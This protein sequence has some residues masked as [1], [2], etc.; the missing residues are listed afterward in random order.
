MST[1]LLSSVLGIR[2]KR[3]MKNQLLNENWNDKH[4]LDGI[5]VIGTML[6]LQTG[7]VDDSPNPSVID[8]DLIIIVWSL[9]NT[10]ISDSNPALSSRLRDIVKPFLVNS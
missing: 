4:P 1:S 3:L 8:L 5:V 6:R 10:S 9:A 7:V 2:I